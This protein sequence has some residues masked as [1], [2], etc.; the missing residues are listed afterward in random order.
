M[1][2]HMFLRIAAL[3]AFI[4]LSS[5]ASAVSGSTS[6]IAA[7]ISPL[8]SGDFGFSVGCP[9]SPDVG[10]VSTPELSDGRIICGLAETGSI[11]S[12]PTTVVSLTITGFDSDPGKNYFSQLNLSCYAEPLLSASAAYSYADG[13]ATWLF[14]LGLAPLPFRVGRPYSLS[15]N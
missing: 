3:A 11:F 2:K 8:V 6:F 1:F 9:G 12:P 10:S 7:T 4:A 5:T 14:N 13:T 15:V